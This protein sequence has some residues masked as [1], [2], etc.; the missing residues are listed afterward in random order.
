MYTD[1]IRVNACPMH[2]SRGAFI[3]AIKGG[4]AR[5][6]FSPHPYLTL[7]YERRGALILLTYEEGHRTRR[8][9]LS[10]SAACTAAEK[11]R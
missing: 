7:T 6:A 4:H 11:A 10:V 1:T 5:G 2:P 3:A 9:V 8:R